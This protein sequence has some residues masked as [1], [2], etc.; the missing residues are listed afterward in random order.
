MHGDCLM[1]PHPLK[2]LERSLNAGRADLVEFRARV[3]ISEIVINGNAR[4]A[5]A[6][7]KKLLG[8][9]LDFSDNFPSN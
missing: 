2:K 1:F 9:L 4:D 5:S 6:A 7:Q 3:D 8:D